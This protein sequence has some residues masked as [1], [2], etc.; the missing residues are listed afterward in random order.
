V[1]QSFPNQPLIEARL[2]NTLA[3]SFGNL[4]EGQ[5]ATEQV[6]PARTIYLKHLGPDD[7]NT[8]AS[9][10]NLANCYVGLG[11]HTDALKLREETLARM[12]AKLGPDHPL[13]LASMNS[14]APWKSG[15]ADGVIA[16]KWDRRLTLGLLRREAGQLI[17]A[18]GTKP[19]QSR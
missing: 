9:T 12:R 15:N 19:E 7:P 5:I 8:L 18:P 1:D 13:T 11:R 6:Q 3:V 17:E 14:R 10:H 4:G 16:P 2:R